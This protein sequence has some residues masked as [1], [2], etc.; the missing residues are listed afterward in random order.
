MK[1]PPRTL[2][3]WLRAPSDISTERTRAWSPPTRACDTLLGGGDPACATPAVWGAGG[4]SWGATRGAIRLRVSLGRGTQPAET[5]ATTCCVPGRVI[6]PNVDVV[7]ALNNSW[8][9]RAFLLDLGRQLGIL[10]FVDQLVQL[11]RVVDPHAK[12]PTAGV[13]VQVDQV[14]VFER[15]GVDLDHLSAERRL[16]RG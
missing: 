5:L 10:F 2:V 8:P 6:T 11:A 12:E 9:K 1:R 13:G 15:L 4:R 3:N 7:K 14:W 16:Q